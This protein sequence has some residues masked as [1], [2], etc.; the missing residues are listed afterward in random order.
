MNRTYTIGELAELAGVSTK[1]LRVYER[2]G[3]LLPE[4]NADNQYRIYTKASVSKL[5]QIQLMKYLG[6]S[7]EQIELFLSK[8]KTAGR[9][10]MLQAQKRL[11][12]R[13][14]EQLQSVI[15]CVEKALAEYKETESD[16]EGLLH[17]L[18]SI[19]KNKKADDLVVRLG[20]HSD[21][22][23]GW[24]EYVFRLADLKQGMRVLDA[25][26]G[27]G[28]LWRY[29]LERLPEAIRVVCV[30]EHNTHCEEFCE[31]IREKE[32]QGAVGNQMFSFVWD[33]LEL[34]E[35]SEKVHCIFF[36][37]VAPFIQDRVKLYRKFCE[38]LTEDGTF[39]CSWGGPLLYRNLLPVL[40]DFLENLTPFEAKKKKQEMMIEGYEKE[41]RSVFAKVTRNEYKTVLRF[42]TAE[43][44]AEYILQMCRSVEEELEQRRP[45]FLEYLSAM[46]SSEG[47]YE[48]ERDTYL[49]SCKGEV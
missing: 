37:H 12:E 22:P 31:F 19:I 46:K 38:S 11:L 49:Y 29:N 27:Y 40:K 15:I 21:E 32:K 4:R 16:S 17:S 41:L 48:L 30:D 44:Y 35:I 13:K 25:G 42:A 2:K 1:T 8:H 24:S 10:E 7:L 14:Q 3:L 36:N 45:E 28:N 33:D 47:G 5:E 23:R 39:F 20:M 26:A 18:G 43:E 6:F 9:K 34:M